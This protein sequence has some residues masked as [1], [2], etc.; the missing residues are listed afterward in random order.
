M[1]NIPKLDG[2]DFDELLNEVKYLARQYTPEWNFDENSSDFGVVFAKVFCSMME[3]TL[4]RY[5][6]TS[7][8][9]YL[10]FL[11]ILGTRLRPA[12]PAFG[13]II[14]KVSDGTDGAYIN[15]GTPLFADA[16]TEDGMVI[17]ETV[18][19]LSA[20]DTSIR[21]I[22]FTEP[23]SDF[24]G[25]VYENFD[26]SEDKKIEPF[27][28]FDNLFYKNLQ[29][30]EIYFGDATVFNMSNTD[31][32]F[33]FYNNISAKGQKFLPEIF[34]DPENVAWEYYKEKKWVPADSMEKTDNG[35]RIRFKG[36]TNPYIIMDVSS[37]FIR[38]RFK[39]VPEGGISVTGITYKSSSEELNADK[40]FSNETELSK[41]DFF[42]F[43]EQYTMY[44]TF[45]FACDEA[46]TKKGA[47]IEVSADIQFVKV[48]IDAQA[49][50]RKYKFIMG[51]TDF[52]DLEPDDIQIEKVKWEY[53]NGS[54]WAKLTP[55]DSCEEF[56]KVNESEETKRTIKF[57]CPEDI[58]SISVGS[59]EGYFIRARVSKMRDQFDFYANYITPYIHDMKIRY[60]YEGEGHELGELVVRSDLEE[61]KVELLDTGLSKVLEKQLCDYPAMYLCLS[62]PLIQGM[63]RIFIDIEEGIH[64]FNPSLKWEYLANNHKGGYEWKHIEIMD[65]TDGFSHSEIVTLIGK[66]DFKEATV[67]GQKGYFVRIINP[68]KKYSVS[69]GM[70]GRPVVNDIKLNAVKVM[71]KDTREPEYFSIEQDEENKLC[72]LSHL[73]VSSV[74]VWVDEL[75]KISTNEQEGFLKMPSN[76]VQTEYDELGKLEKLWVKWQPVSNLVAHGM[77]DRVYE[78]DYPKGEIIFGNGRNGKIPSQQYNESI[79]ISYSIC[80]GSKGNIEAHKVK[81]FVNTIPNID[82]IYNPS[83]IMGGVDMETID[84]AAK[85]MFGQ[86]SGGNRL[87]SLSDFE[88]SICSND[89]NIYKVKCISHMDEDS[90]PSLGATSIAVLPREFMQG[91]EKFQ[92][93]KNKIWKFVDEKA[94]ATLSQSVR[95]RIFEVGYV[96]TSVSVDIIIDD[97]NS[98]QSVYKGI[99]SRLKEFLNPVS[100]NFSR[101]GWKIG[102]F[103][104]KE[105]IYNYIKTV[106][107][108]KWIK[109]INIFTK[110]ITPEGKKELDFEEI[111]NQ[112]FVVPVFGEPEINITVN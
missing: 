112:H 61:Y 80:N 83:P 104:R 102:E 76:Q 7:Y 97:F 16:D 109:K 46:F 107:N 81:D 43:G 49:P 68:D 78:V 91:Y 29:C 28:I 108:I 27:R 18:D 13:M 39:R 60:N 77:N 26:E 2:R 98:Y 73:N 88:D 15:K 105:F 70:A 99:E 19:S 64:R 106:K 1:S 57:K 31:I 21:S 67:L 53:W 63:I 54:G 35:V 56:F 82:S 48:K 20:I 50:G 9:H 41:N 3:S 8:N 79:K 66:N 36:T 5:N 33:S 14:A 94:P 52:A 59:A 110:L 32:N 4:S 11:N 38:C 87:V 95:L 6:K 69:K 30:H 103:P 100:G 17:Y 55:E 96:E 93:I 58:E 22:Y 71:Q 24:I 101:R 12:A 51:N 45:S 75:G 47:I 92:G 72:K 74:E 84:N 62:R 42:P 86:I 34:A 37:R 25:C 10:T 23:V 85:R 44:N 40:F 111:K 90:K 65:G 89:R